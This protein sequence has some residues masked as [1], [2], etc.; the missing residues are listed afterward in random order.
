MALGADRATVLGMILRQV[1]W[2]A[3]GGIALGTAAALVAT[4]VVESL[5]YGVKANDTA[6]FAIAAGLV[7]AV[8]MLAVAIPARRAMGV[9]PVRALRYE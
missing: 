2:T 9:D 5:L 7:L 3:G 8:A 6:S 4:K 1:L